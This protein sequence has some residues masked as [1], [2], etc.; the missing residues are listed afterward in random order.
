MVTHTPAETPPHFDGTALCVKVGS[1]FSCCASCVPLSRV[2]NKKPY[3]LYIHPQNGENILALPQSCF[4]SDGVKLDKFTDKHFIEWLVFGM[5]T[6]T[7]KEE[8][9]Y[10]F[11]G[12]IYNY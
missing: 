11:E 9:Y 12:A 7:E 8:V 5:G 6:Y 1:P 10:C 4:D 3:E 2:V